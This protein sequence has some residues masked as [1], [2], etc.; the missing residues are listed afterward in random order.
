MPINRRAWLQTALC[1]GAGLLAPRFLRGTQISNS[2]MSMP[3]TTQKPVAL[4]RYVDPLPVPSVIHA[5]EHSGTLEI[6]MRE[7]R[8]R[9]HR[10]LPPTSMWGYNGTWP[11]PTLEVSRGQPLA[12]KWVNALPTKHFLPIDHTIHGAEESLPEA[13]AVVHVH[14]AQVLPE[15]DGYPEAWSTSNGN[16]GPT[17]T[18]NPSHYPNQQPAAMLWYHDHCLG[19]T[20]LNVYA[21]LAGL[22]LIRDPEEDALNLPGGAYEIPLLIQDRSF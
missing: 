11:G 20:R 12:V 5:S 22:Y 9:A 3:S 19:I 15:S 13:R 4:A 21:G 7:F 18:G 6:R 10:D 1:S 14:G 17:W 16:T 2:G 8:H